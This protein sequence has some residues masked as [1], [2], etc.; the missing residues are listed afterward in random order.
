MALICPVAFLTCV[1][2]KHGN[3][4][5]NANCV[6]GCSSIET[7]CTS[8]GGGGAEVEPKVNTEAGFCFFFKLYSRPLLNA[9]SQHT[10]TDD[11]SDV[12]LIRLYLC[13]RSEL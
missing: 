3:I 12:R 8:A 1:R 10:Q 5:L 6:A 2:F 11:D 9:S 4:R 13:R 7:D